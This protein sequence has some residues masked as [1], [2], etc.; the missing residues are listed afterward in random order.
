MCCTR[1]LCT[2]KCR[3][4][5]IGIYGVWRKLCT[6][7]SFTSEL[8]KA[9]HLQSTSVVLRCAVDGAMSP[10]KLKD[11]VRFERDTDIEV[12]KCERTAFVTLFKTN[13]LL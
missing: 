1:T 7:H 8:P 11:K 5:A 9:L 4:V 12:F 3:G 13:R 6:M 2:D 10:S